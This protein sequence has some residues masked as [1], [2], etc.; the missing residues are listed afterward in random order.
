MHVEVIIK[1]IKT[2]LIVRKKASTLYIQTSL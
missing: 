2:S 1:T